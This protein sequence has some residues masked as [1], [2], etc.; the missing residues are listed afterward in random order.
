MATPVRMEGHAHRSSDA[1]YVSVA[2]SA[3]HRC[4]GALAAGVV[5]SSSF[6]R[7]RVSGKRSFT[8]HGQLS[9][10]TGTLTIYPV[11]GDVTDH[12]DDTS[13]SRTAVTARQTSVAMTTSEAAVTHTCKG[14]EY[15]DVE[16][17]A[18]TIT[19]ID[20]FGI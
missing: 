14:E 2:N 12:D 4:I 20:C 10:G 19:F 16:L 6:E 3:P 17:S 18:G 13:G 5:A 7:I 15:V 1:A 9:A 11:L 8:V